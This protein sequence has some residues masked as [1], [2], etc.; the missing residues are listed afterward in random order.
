MPNALCAPID[1]R[2]QIDA[3]VILVD[4]EIL[5]QSFAGLPQRHSIFDRN[6][7]DVANAIDKLF[8]AAD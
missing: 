8:K 1:T 6:D 3:L 7:G 4:W 5:S 2:P